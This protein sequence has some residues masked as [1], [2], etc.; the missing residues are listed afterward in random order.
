MLKPIKVRNFLSQKVGVLVPL[1]DEELISDKDV[2][3]I[4]N[5]FN[6]HDVYD[7]LFKR[8][9]KN[10]AFTLENVKRYIKWSV[11]QTL[12]KNNITYIIRDKNTIVC[13]GIDLQKVDSETATIGYWAD[14]KTPGF[15]T[16]AVKEIIKVAKEIGYKNIDAYP[17]EGNEKSIKVLNRLDFKYVEK[18]IKPDKVLL[19]YLTS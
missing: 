19:K 13:G 1:L 6:S 10:R 18:I 14:P 5:I 3:Q 9:L 17:E 4:K 8:T 16:N 12:N 2:Q 11:T 7:R 15:I